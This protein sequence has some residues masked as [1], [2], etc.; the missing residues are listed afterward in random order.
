M[1]V[2]SVAS[3][4]ILW[5]FDIKLIRLQFLKKIDSTLGVKT[6]QKGQT[7]GDLLS[8]GRNGGCTSLA[9]TGHVRCNS[10][11]V[12]QTTK[13]KLG[14]FLL[15]FFYTLAQLHG[16]VSCYLDILIHSCMELILSC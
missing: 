6:V 4:N 8:F 16:I 10:T 3:E 12:C 9:Q 15:K 13:A 11:G 7:R 1:S 2:R 5:V 14:H